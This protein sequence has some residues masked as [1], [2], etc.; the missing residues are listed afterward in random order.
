[1]KPILVSLVTTRS[2]REK[3][4]LN[5]FRYQSGGAFADRGSIDFTNWRHFSCSAGKKRLVCGKHIFKIK[6]PDIDTVT[7]IARYLQDS[8]TRNAHQNRV[9]LVIGQHMPVAHDEKVFTRS[10]S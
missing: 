1:M 6:R 2:G 8:L 9:A 3:Y 4:A 5:L 10:F 7:Q